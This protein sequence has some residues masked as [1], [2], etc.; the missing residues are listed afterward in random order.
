ML[1]VTL[2][3]ILII[4]LSTLGVIRHLIYETMWTE[5][6]SGL[7]I[8]MPEKFNWFHLT[9]LITKVLLMWKRTGLFL[10][11]N[12]LLRCWGWLSLLNWIGALTLSLLLKLPP[13][14]LEPWFFL[15]SLFLLGLHCI[16]I[17]LPYGHASNTVAI[18]GLVPLA[19]TW[20]C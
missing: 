17:N 14:K 6:G 20:H 9:R 5:A 13:R 16:S 19:A 4:L 3:S 11:K 7:L 1:S 2:L 12:H 15:W 8:S 18:P 10:R